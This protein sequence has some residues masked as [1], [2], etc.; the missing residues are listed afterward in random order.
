MYLGQFALTQ[1]AEKA[2]DDSCDFST[3]NKIT[4]VKWSCAIQWQIFYSIAFK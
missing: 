3:V 4:Y 2:N 1:I